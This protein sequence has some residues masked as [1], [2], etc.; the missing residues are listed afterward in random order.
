MTSLNIAGDYAEICGRAFSGC[1]KLQ[2]VTLSGVEALGNS[3]AFNS[4]SKLQ[5]FTADSTLINI[6]ERSFYENKLLE[7]FVWGSG[8][9]SGTIGSYAFSEC[10]ALQSI[11]IPDQVESISDYVFYK[12]NSLTSGECGLYV[13]ALFFEEKLKI[14]SDKCVIPLNDKKGGENP[15]GDIY[16]SD[17]YTLNESIM[18]CN[19]YWANPVTTGVG[20]TTLLENAY[21]GTP[22]QIAV[23]GDKAVMVYQGVDRNADSAANALTLYYSVY[24]P[25]TLKWS[26][27]KKIES[28]RQADLDFK[29]VSNGDKAYVLYTQAN[30]ELSADCGLSDV[31]KKIDVYSAEFDSASETF[32]GFNRLTSD[33]S[34]D[35][36]PTIKTIGGS[37]TAVWVSNS[38]GDP[39]LN[40]G[41]NTLKL[42]KLENGEWSAPQT[43]ASTEE[44]IINCSL[45]ASGRTPVAVYTADSDNDLLTTEDRKLV[46]FNT[47]S[48]ESQTIA[49]GVTSAVEIGELMGND[50]VM[51]YDNDEAKMKQYNVKT[52][53]ITSIE[54][55][56]SSAAKDFKLVS[57]E[58][59]K[60][61]LVFLYEN[62]ICAKYFNTETETWS[63]PV[64]IASSDNTIENI[65][66]QYVNGKLNVT[67]YDTAVTDNE[68]MTIESDLKTAVA[69]NTPKPPI[70]EASVD[71]ESIVPGDQAEMAVTVMNNSSE[72]T[73]NLSFTVTNYD[74]TV[75]GSY[76][77][78]TVSLKAGEIKDFVI[79]FT[80][81]DE[82]VNRNVIVTVTDSTKTGSFS[83]KVKLAIVDYGI[84]ASQLH[85]DDGEYIKAY[86][87]NN[88]SYTSP[89]TLEVYDRFTGEVFYS[90]NIPK[91]EKDYPMT[92]LIKAERN[93]VDKNGY[94]SVRI[95]TKADD[96]YD[97]DNADMFQY[98][99]GEAYDDPELLIGDVNLDGEI[100]I[101]DATA[102]SKHLVNL[103][104]L[105][106]EA[107]A[108]ADINGDADIDINDVTCIQK[109]LAGFT[110]Y[111]SCGQK[112][113]SN[114]Q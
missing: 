88:T 95:V 34:Y 80:A 17:S 19:P 46:V 100:D 71:H 90:I 73:G 75:L 22:A 36:M 3:G 99:P 87:Y 14:F 6:G 69:A 53:A 23:C 7:T 98:I 62:I 105:D 18:T 35:T 89:A 84:Y 64:E 4:C 112:L 12:S 113:V 114:A 72:P 76:T 97:M 50:V 58:N 85:K 59:G 41:T 51:W 104:T 42:S 109:Y 15:I 57:D 11:V 96:E 103:I 48:N 83:E 33:E 38:E 79:P 1:S 2:S 68:K 78:E 9:G 30:S 27:P 74:G 101:N 31:T 67:Y 29:L 43:V 110:K 21:S 70:L 40:E 93:Y 81:P 25:E 39:F 102:I 13:K 65:S 44:T 24:D 26:K 45:A 77:T 86:V 16:N 94:I 32:A 52:S 55:I 108:V 92:A 66:A 91:I 61:A 37:P 107:L 82:I 106:G 10:G 5:S 28:N 54:D 56:P 47:S 111:G 8:S 20:T 63:D 49:Q 60:T